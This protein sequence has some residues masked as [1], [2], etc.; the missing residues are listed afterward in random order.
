MRLYPPGWSFGRKALADDEIGGF[1]VPAGSLVWVSPYITH[2][3]PAFWER[4]EE[5]DPERFTPERVASR[6]RFTYF[7]FSSGPRICI[8]SHLA[9]MVA[10]LTLAAVVQRFRL[11]L[12]AGV[13]VAPE[14]LI[15]LHP[16]G[17]VPLLLEPR[18]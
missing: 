1:H 18:S 14:A 17:S 6:P 4:P 15:T 10:Q 5:F 11:R 16:R 12:P 9:M 13:Q 8:G 3:H 7:P 2:R